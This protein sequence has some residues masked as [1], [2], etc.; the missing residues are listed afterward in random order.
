MK[1]GR[2][3]FIYTF[4]YMA[5]GAFCPMIGKYLEAEGMTGTQI[6]TVTAAGTCTAI[7][8]GIFWGRI[9]AK[10]SRRRLVIAGLCILAST[11]CILLMRAG[12][13]IWT[14]GL[15][16]L[17][18]F[19]QGPIL[20]LVDAMCVEEKRAFGAARLWGAVGY[21]AGVLAGGVASD[22]ISLSAIFVIYIGCYLAAAAV[23]LAGGKTEKVNRIENTR[24][25]KGYIELF[26]NK[27]F[28]RLII[29]V[30]FFGGTNVA[31]NTYYSFMFTECGGTLAGAGAAMF[32]MIA[33]EAPFMG[34]S[35]RLSNRFTLEKMVLAAMVVSAMRF[36]LYGLGLPVWVVTGLFVLQG[37]ANGIALVEIIRYVAEIVDEDMMG[38]ATSA[39]YVISSNLSTIVCQI[40]GGIVLEHAGGCSVYMMFAGYNLIGIG[41]YVV[42]GLHNNN[43]KVDICY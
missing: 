5:I 18:Y 4:T 26:M 32:L 20:A 27:K 41:L 37:F 19:F 29:S 15:Y 1:A 24:K 6:G 23:I 8:A 17:M 42:Y 13:M 40:L 35:F 16:A 9:Y 39:Y 36:G 14:I 43:E 10:S 12:G 2:F 38:L 22:K 33:A 30:F 7:L 34:L 3:I 31:N 25:K 28:R 21:A 11:V